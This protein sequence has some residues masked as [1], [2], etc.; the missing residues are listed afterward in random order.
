MTM[1]PLDNEPT[2]QQAIRHAREAR[3]R[4]TES[5]S[6]CRLESIVRPPKVRDRVIED[7]GET[8]E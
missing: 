4:R 3:T 7:T 1:G 5:R 6:A 2:A 8:V